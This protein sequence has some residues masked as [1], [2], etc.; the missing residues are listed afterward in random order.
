MKDFRTFMML[1]LTLM[2]QTLFVACGGDDDDSTGIVNEQITIGDDGKASN[3][4]VFSSIDD[5]N[6]YLDYIKYTVTEGHLAVSGYDKS[7]FKGDAK[8]VSSITYKGN[9]YEVL[10]IGD[11]AFY[12][13]KALVSISIP[14]CVTSIGKS[15]FHSCYGITNVTIPNN[16]TKIGDCA[17]AYC[18]GLVSISIPTSVTEIGENAFI[19]CNALTSM[20]IKDLSAWCK[21]NFHNYH[22]NPLAL[23]HHLYV[24]GKEVEDLIIPDGVTGISSY[25]FTQCNYLNSITINKN[26]TFIGDHAFSGCSG[27]TTITV[28]DGNPNYDSRDNCNAIIEKSTN[29][30]LVGCSN[31]VIP[32]NVTRIGYYAFEGSKH[33]GNSFTIPANV[34]SIGYNAFLGC[35]GLTSLRIE[36]SEQELELVN[37]GLPYS[38]TT[39]YIGRNFTFQNGHYDYMPFSHHD[40]LESLT[41]GSGCTEIPSNAFAYCSRLTT[42]N[43]PN[44]ITSIGDQAFEGCSNLTTI[45]FPSRLAYINRWA[46]MGCDKIT[47]IHCIGT[48]PSQVNSGTTFDYIIYDKATLYVPQGSV[49]AYKASEPWR[50]FINIIEE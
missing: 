1:M 38:L 47:A 17:F 35:D 16:V 21:I 8:I 44:S 5:K 7:G 9:F 24:N 49:G 30:L 19:E 4:G 26:V 48:T 32:F 40:Q 27:L 6:F 50:Y 34:T 45:T 41:F 31:T 11:K 23:I 3:G 10:E 2:A 18:Y 43:F 14:S 28:E 12:D 33:L 22:S 46:F 37:I 25:A 36:D 39:L 13:C 20:D 15:A 29:T 42:L